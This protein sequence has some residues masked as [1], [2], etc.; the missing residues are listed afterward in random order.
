[1]R[2]GHHETCGI[3]H[4]SGVCKH[5]I[6]ELKEEPKQVQAPEEVWV[7]VN[8]RGE[9]TGACMATSSDL[10]G[11]EKAGFALVRYVKAGGQ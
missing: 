7:V 5:T 10:T 9:P 2:Y 1:M 11:W 8:W 4:T 3:C 6:V